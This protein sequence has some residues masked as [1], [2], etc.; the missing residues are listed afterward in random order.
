MFGRL[1]PTHDWAD[2][3]LVVRVY[4]IPR[5]MSSLLFILTYLDCVLLWKV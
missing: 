5:A 1:I 3:M 4:I 2:T